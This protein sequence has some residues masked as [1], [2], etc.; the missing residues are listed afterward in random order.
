MIKIISLVLIILF[1][2]SGTAKLYAE[3][4]AIGEEIVKKEVIKIS[5]WRLSMAE[6]T[7]E[8]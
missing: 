6:N 2:L 4:S 3:Y 7:R 5:S 8:K 1:C